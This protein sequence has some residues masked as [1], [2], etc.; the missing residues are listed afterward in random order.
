M[1][2]VVGQRVVVHDHIVGYSDEG[3]HQ[4]RHHA[5]AVFA[6]RAVEDRG[7]VVAVSQMRDHLGQHV[8]A[9]GKALDV[10]APEVALSKSRR[11][12][13]AGS[14][15]PVGQWRMEPT[16]GRGLERTPPGAFE[17]D[18]GPQVDDGADPELDEPF[19]R[20]RCEVMEGVAAEHH[21]M[22][23]RGAIARRQTPEVTEVEGPVELDEAV[24]RN[25]HARTVRGRSNHP[26]TD[27][28]TLG[29]VV[30]LPMRA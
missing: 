3:Q 24:Q 22:P 27:S 9:R 7:Q 10:V 26:V 16:D 20:G 1:H 8:A 29:V 2:P 21:T 15:V 30:P 5:G 28:E 19:D 12:H 4:R 11:Q 18:R 6:C 25:C 14:G 17:F 23:G 13:V